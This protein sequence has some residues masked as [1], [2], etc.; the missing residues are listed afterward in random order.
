[1]DSDS[2]STQRKIT[3]KCCFLMY[4]GYINWHF[5]IR[6]PKCH[7]VYPGYIKQHFTLVF[8]CA[9]QQTLFR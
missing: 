5:L 8:F 6:K 2:R 9:L 7:L 3:V 1:M 4:P